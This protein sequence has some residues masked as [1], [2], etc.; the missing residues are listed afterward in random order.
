[1]SCRNAQRLTS[2]GL[3]PELGGHQPGDVRSLEQVAEHVLPVAGAVAQPAQDRPQPLV[4]V[5][6]ADLGQRVVG[7]AQAEL[8]DLGA[9]VLVGVLDAVRVDPA[10]GHQRL[11]GEPADLAPDRVEAGQQHRLGGVVDDHVDAGDRL[12][13][14]DVAALAADDPALHL[15]GGQ[16][17]HADDGLGRSGR[18][19]PVAPPRPRSARARSSASFAWPRPRS[20]GLAAPPLGGRRSRPRCSARP[21]PGRWSDRRCARARRGRSAG[22]ARP[23]RRLARPARRPAARARRPAAPA[24][25]TCRSMPGRL[26][27]ERQLARSSTDRCPCGQLGCSAV[28]GAAWASRAAPRLPR[29][30]SEHQAEHERR[31]HGGVEDAGHAAPFPCTTCCSRGASS[32]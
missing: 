9:A 13:G 6:D 1:M 8:V 25:L 32:H 7:G 19:R 11:Q 20:C 2:V 4:E 15:L 29:V 28:E 17:Q 10:V 27:S 23:A 31:G 12:E 21:A 18:W 26:G 30:S 22:R 16:V 3:E 24:R 14:A 5:M